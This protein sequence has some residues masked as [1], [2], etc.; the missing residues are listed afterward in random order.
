MV[1][2]VAV[3]AAVVAAANRLAPH[4]QPRKQRPPA[5]LH[6]CLDSTR[7]GSALGN[8]AAGYSVNLSFSIYTLSRNWRFRLHLH[9]YISILTPAR[10]CGVTCGTSAIPHLQ[11]CR[12]AMFLTGRWGWVVR[13]GVGTE[14]GA[15]MEEIYLG[16]TGSRRGWCEREGVLKRPRPRNTC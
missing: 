16:Q 8:S 1:V 4:I 11:N 3:V 6:R 5:L 2:A 12:H 13:R 9:L 10:G 7:H 15:S 14:S